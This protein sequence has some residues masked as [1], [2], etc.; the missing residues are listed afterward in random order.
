MLRGMLIELKLSTLPVWEVGP[1]LLS[2]VAWPE[3]VHDGQKMERHHAVLCRHYIDA[4]VETDPVWAMTASIKPLY[5]SVAER[6]IHR[7]VAGLHRNLD[8][9][10]RAARMAIPFLQQAAGYT[11]GL[12]KEMPRLSLNAAAQ[13][14]TEDAGIDDPQNVKRLVWRPCLPIIHIATAIAVTVNN[15]EILIKEKAAQGEVVASPL[16]HFLFFESADLIRA[17]VQ[18]SEEHAEHMAKNQLLRGSVE[19]RVRLVLG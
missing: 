8:R 10:M 4:R 18:G 19:E 11:V 14:I 17:I 1:A 2:L 15:V 12:P 13:L 5:A 6:E 7:H 16:W 3:D 9:A